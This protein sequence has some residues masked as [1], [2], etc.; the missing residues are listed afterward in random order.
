MTK[1]TPIRKS[2]PTFISTSTTYNLI[3]FN[4]SFWECFELNTN[5]IIKARAFAKKFQP[6]LIRKNV[7]KITSTTVK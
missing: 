2:F 6:S 3:S 4:G 7:T 1:P 5:S